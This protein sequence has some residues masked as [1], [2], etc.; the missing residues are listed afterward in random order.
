MKQRIIRITLLISLFVLLIFVNMPLMDKNK[1]KTYTLPS[2]PR[3]IA[4][5]PVI[6]T[7]AGQSTDT[8]IIRDVSNQLMIR[9][10]FMPQARSAD[11]KEAKTIVLVVGYS[12]LGTKL[13][14]KSYEEEKMRIEK[15]IEKAKENNS[16]ILTVVMGGEQSHNNTEELLRLIGTQSDYMIGLRESSN[17]SILTELAKERDIPLTLVSGVNDISEPFASAFR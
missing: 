8:Y 2:L 16:T 10:F 15:L 4:E 13:Q 12:S 14:S 6:I 11:L 7:S 17:E 9:S 5:E 3:P 1:T